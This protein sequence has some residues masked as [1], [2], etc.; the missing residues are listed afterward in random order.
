[1]AVNPYLMFE[2]EAKEAAGLYDSAFQTGHAELMN[3]GEVPGGEYA[4]S[5]DKDL[6]IHGRINVKGTEIIF[7]DGGSQSDIIKGT[8]ITV[9]VTDENL[10]YITNAYETLSGEGQI[11]MHLQETFFAKGHAML[12]DQF[13]I[14][15]QLSCPN[16]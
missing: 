8:N 1:M 11:E 13:G 2:N 16:A 14:K 4:D 3:Y 6:I 5:P 7:S 15:W 9:A 12:T 10:N